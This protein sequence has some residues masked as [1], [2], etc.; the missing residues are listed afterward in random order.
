MQSTRNFCRKLMFRCLDP[1]SLFPCLI[2]SHRKTHTTHTHTQTYSTHSTHTIRYVEPN[3]TFDASTYFAMFTNDGTNTSDS[4]PVSYTAIANMS[5]LHTT[6][7]LISA[8]D[9]AYLRNKTGNEDASIKIVNHPLVMTQHQR[10]MLGAL[11]S[12][13]VVFFIGLAI[14]FI[15][16]AVCEYLVYE[17][18]HEVK[19]QQLV[20][21]VSLAAYWTSSFVWDWIQ[22]L[23]TATVCV[24]LIVG[25]DISQYTDND[26]SQFKC[27]ILLFVLYGP[28]A[29][30][31]AY[32]QA[33]L[34]KKPYFAVNCLLVFN[35]VCLIASLAVTILA[36]FDS[37]CETSIWLRHIFMIIPNYAFI[38]GFYRLSLLSGLPFAASICD[39]SVDVTTK[40]DALE[41]RAVGL[42]LIYMAASIVV[43]PLLAVA[44]DTIYSYPSMQ[45]YVCGGLEPEVQDDG[46]FEDD[47]DVKRVANETKALVRDGSDDDNKMVQIRGLRKVYRTKDKSGNTV[48]KA[49]VK[50]TWLTVDRGECFGLLGTNGAGKSTTFKMLSGDVLP[51]KGTALLGHR[52]V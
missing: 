20:S 23:V 24:L 13:G 22:Y 12:S 43:Y 16:A 32:N 39:S 41:I 26:E 30:G 35:L 25:F 36:F 14:A 9:S 8:I 15:P 17:T 28:A 45:Q 33:Y 52:D 1:A 29:I 34:F 21:G 50:D 5:A 40:W 7:L 27:V 6:P 4:N 37:T 44:I 49:A 31:L 47:Q 18:Y 10:A 19:H 3:A 42:N 2:H 11:S 46:T 38:D 48:L 51:S